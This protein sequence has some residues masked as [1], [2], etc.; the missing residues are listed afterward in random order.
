[1]IRKLLNDPIT[2]YRSIDSLDTNDEQER[3]NFPVEFLNALNFS[4][5]PP[6]DLKLK[7]VAIVVLIRNLNSERN[8]VYG[9]RLSVKAQNAN[10][11]DAK[12][13]TEKRQDLRLL[14]QRID[15]IE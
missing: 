13:L 1:M 9:T 8:Y 12:V 5:M 2:A 3:N 15:I 7:E 14:I 11:F 4:G 10:V 6:H